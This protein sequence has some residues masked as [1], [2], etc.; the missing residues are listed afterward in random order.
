MSAP[1]LHIPVLIME[2]MVILKSLTEMLSKVAG[3]TELHFY[4]PSP[5]QMWKSW[6][7][8]LFYHL[9]SVPSQ[10]SQITL[11]FTSYVGN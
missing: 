5:Y 1:R 3:V 7:L 8:Q 2:N 9:L 10:L 4:Y 6:C 11:L